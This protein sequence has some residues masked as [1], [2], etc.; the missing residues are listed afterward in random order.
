[1]SS[2]RSIAQKLEAERQAAER[3]NKEMKTKLAELES[4][5]KNRSRAQVAA[6]EAKIGHLDEQ[7]SAEST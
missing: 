1:M 4:S 7:L 2:E 6:L 3:Q 5:A